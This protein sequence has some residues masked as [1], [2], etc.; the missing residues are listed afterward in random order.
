MEFPY[1]GVED[2]IVLKTQKDV[3]RSKI[4]KDP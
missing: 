4:V 3:S 2:L 1:F